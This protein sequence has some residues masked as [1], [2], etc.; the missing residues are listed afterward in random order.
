MSLYHINFVFITYRFVFITCK[1][2]CLCNIS[3]LSLQHINFV[4]ATYIFLSLQPIIY[5]FATYNICL[6]TMF[7]YLQHINLYIQYTK[8]PTNRILYVR[9]SLQNVKFRALLGS[10][11]LATGSYFGKMTP[12]GP[13]TFLNG[14]WT[15]K[16]IFFNKKME[17]R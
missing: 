9:I 17:N 3:N 5:V 7:L 13:R 1:F 6:C 8:G 10:P 11:W 4:F 2:I 15:S 14:F 12:R 16:F